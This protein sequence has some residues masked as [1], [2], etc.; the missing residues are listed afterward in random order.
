[1]Q[2]RNLGTSG[3]H[4]QPTTLS[5]MLGSTIEMSVPAVNV[6]DLSHLADYMGEEYAAMVSV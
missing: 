4:M 6:V 5:Q 1:M 3:L 2:S